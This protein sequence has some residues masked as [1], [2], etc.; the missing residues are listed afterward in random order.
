MIT[1]GLVSKYDGKTKRSAFENSIN[2]FW[3][4]KNPL[5]IILSFAS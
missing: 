3:L 4:L 2:R 5:N 1:L